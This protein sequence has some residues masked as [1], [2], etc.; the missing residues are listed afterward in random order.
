MVSH[1]IDLTQKMARYHHCHS[2]PARQFADELP[3][4]LNTGRVQ[5]VGRLVQ[6]EQPGIA[7]QGCRKTEPLFHAQ[8]VVRHLFSL[9][10]VQTDDLKHL[11]DILFRYAPEGLHNAQV[12]LAGEMAVVARTLD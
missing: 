6:N 8:R 4:L 2:E 10:T 12:F 5:T 1:L 9:L 7:Q 3:H 11:P